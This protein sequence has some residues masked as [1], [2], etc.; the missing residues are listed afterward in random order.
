MR[1]RAD[2]LRPLFILVAASVSIA[3]RTP[4]GTPF[5]IERLDPALDAIVS[6]D[7][8]LEA[9]NVSQRHHVVA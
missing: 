3:A 9:G 4:G 1:Q 5:R 6:P 2:V 7:A 8:T